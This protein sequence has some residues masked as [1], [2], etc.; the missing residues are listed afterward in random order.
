MLYVGT[1]RN[2]IRIS[3]VRREW[4]L[5][6]PLRNSDD[7]CALGHYCSIEYLYGTYTSLRATVEAGKTHIHMRDG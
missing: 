1:A 4:Q 3:L 5:R 6:I 2:Q 7:N